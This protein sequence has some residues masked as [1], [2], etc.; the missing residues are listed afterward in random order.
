M[1]SASLVLSSCND[2]VSKEDDFM[3][4]NEAGLAEIYLV[5]P[6]DEPRGFC[7]DIRGYKE[8]ADIKKGLQA[9]TCYSYQ[10]NIAVDQ[11]FSVEKI[12]VG[13]FYIPNFEVCIEAENTN[14]SSALKL[15]SCSKGGLQK[16]VINENGSISLENNKNLCV[17]ISSER[18]REGGG[19][20]P[21]HLIRNLN[22]ENCNLI[23]LKYQTWATRLNNF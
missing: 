1:F 12:S 2:K 18:S 5:D 23:N 16:F 4:Y 7:F 9:H 6:L 22:L 11:G 8:S 10:G 19:G 13:E 14:P 21:P 3:N 15:E 20:N 17:T